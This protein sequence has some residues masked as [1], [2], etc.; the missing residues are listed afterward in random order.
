[1]IKLILFLLTTLLLNTVIYAQNY[2]NEV[3]KQFCGTDELHYEIFKNHPELNNKIIQNHNFLNEFTR[4]FITQKDNKSIVYKIPVV[5]HIIHNYG[6]ENISNAQIYDAIRVANRNLRKQN[7]DTTDIVPFFKPRAADCE[8]ELVLA[9]KD[10][11]GNCHSGINRIASTLTYIGDH[12]VKSLIHW[13]PTKYLNI[14]VCAEAAGL[15]GH[16][17]LPSTADTLPQW[18]GIVIQHSYLGSIG[19]STPFKSVVLTHELGHYFNLQHIWGGNNVPGFYYLPVAQQANCNFD[20]DVLDTPN[21]IGWQTCNLNGTSCDDTL[22]NVQNFMDYAY[23]ARML[24]YGQRDRMHACLNSPIAGRNNLW[25]ATNLAATGTDGSNF[26]CAADFVADKQVICAGQQVKFADVSYHGIQ[27]RSWNFQGGTPSISSDSSVTVTY[28]TPGTYAVTL[29]VSDGNNTL[30][31][32]ETAYITVLS[33]IGNAIPFAENFESFSDLITNN[34]FAVNPHNDAGFELNSNVGFSGNKSVWINNHS[35]TENGSKDELISPVYNFSNITNLQVS[36][37]YAYARKDSTSNDRLNIFLTSNCGNTWQIKKSINA[38][39][40]STAPDQSTPFTPNATQWKTDFI[41]NM[42]G[43]QANTPFRIRFVFENGGGNNFYLDDIN[44]GYNLNNMYEIITDNI[45]QLYPNPSN[46]VVTLKFNN[47][48][49]KEISIYDLK[50]KNIYNTIC[51]ADEMNIDVSNIES[52]IYFIEIKGL[53][54][55]NTKKLI[56]QH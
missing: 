11:N 3:K 16:A 5:F 53:N 48:I 46:N 52:G 38:N 24:T 7:P 26:F 2:Y 25:T 9:Q 43:I 33:N 56:I 12:Q 20:D 27:S 41:T 40:L 54:G 37:K 14:Y 28:S 50:G 34:W 13:D 45:F 32:N 8:I 36:F 18:D 44:I 6:T 17:L 30:T 19:T 21:T 35:I 29:Q 1:M 10:P 31:K 15:A 47:Y 4:N 42:N 39:N 55:V 49:R 23:C 51:T 22:D